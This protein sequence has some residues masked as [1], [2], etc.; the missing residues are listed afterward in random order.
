MAFMV[1][2]IGLVYFIFLSHSGL[3]EQKY[4]NSRISSLR[5]DI[6]R[7]EV[8]NHNLKEKFRII[9]D[10]SVAL[11]MEARKFYLLSENAHVI[12]FME[13][14]VKEDRKVLAENRIQLGYPLQFKP[15]VDAITVI[16]YF[17]LGFAAMAGLGLMIR[18][19]N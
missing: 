17:Y 1:I 3:L 19:K 13:K 11:E 16:R 5:L 6:E 2:G 15:D 9:K 10:D 7:L 8:E 4:L 14:R 18:M 12:K